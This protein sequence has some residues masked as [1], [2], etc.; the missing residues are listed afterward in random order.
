M[1]VEKFTNIIGVPFKEYVSKQLDVRAK[2]ISTTIN[3]TNDNILFLANKN[4]WIKLTSFVTVSGSYAGN[5]S[6]STPLGTFLAEN[7]TLFGGT[8]YL[9][10]NTNPPSN[11]LRFGIEQ[12]AISSNDPG[13]INPEVLSITNNSAYGLGGL[14]QQ[15]YKVMPG[16]Q[17][18]K[19]QHMGTAGSLRSATVT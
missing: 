12:N 16:I 17:S 5:L 10:K 7:W 6:E 8:S 14:S 3:R 9:N 11:N 4:C 13:A 2:N 19:I 18:A 15:G 1:A